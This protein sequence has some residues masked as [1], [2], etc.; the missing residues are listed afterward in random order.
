MLFSTQTDGVVAAAAIPFPS[1]DSKVLWR[2]FNAAAE[3][4]GPAVI[5]T[6][7]AVPYRE[8]VWSERLGRYEE[9]ESSRMCAMSAA[10]WTNTDAEGRLLDARPVDGYASR[11]HYHL[12][13]MFDCPSGGYRVPRPLRAGERAFAHGEAMLRLLAGIGGD[14][15]FAADAVAEAKRLHAGKPVSAAREWKCANIAGVAERDAFWAAPFA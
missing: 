12:W 6:T 13:T 4:Y 9:W 8:K 2:L 3:A 15:L 14:I 10:A 7:F 1:D 5:T 11:S